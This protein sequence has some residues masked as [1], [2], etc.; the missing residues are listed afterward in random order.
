MA[1][2]LGPTFGEETIA[3]GLGGLPF[4]W[5]AT[6]ETISGRENLTAAQNTTLDQVI[7]AHD[8][9]KRLKNIIPTTDFIARFTNQE[10][11]A[12]GK[13]RTADIAANKVGYSK[14]W[15]IVVTSDMVDLNKQKSQTIKEDLV[16]SGVLTQARADEIFQ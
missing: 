3:A 2:Q 7:A 13:Q 11:L 8:P 9:T 5:G 6:D 4:T 15:D 1:K 14:N 16:A 10:Y 12:V